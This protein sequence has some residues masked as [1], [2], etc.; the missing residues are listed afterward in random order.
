MMIN[1]HTSTKNGNMHP[2]RTIAGANTKMAAPPDVALDKSRNL[3][4]VAD[5]IDIP[6]FSSAATATGNIAP[7]RSLGLT[8]TVSAIFLDSTNDRLFA[9]NSAG[10]AI[11]VFD[12]ASTL[13]GPVTANRTI[14]GAATHLGAPAGIQI[15]G[16]GTLV[17]SNASSHNITIYNNA[18][19]ATG[20]LAPSAQIVCSNSGATVHEPSIVKTAGPGR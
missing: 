4:Y 18:A 15:D 2:E 10:N 6:V 11:A 1:D 20:N 3:L 13:N 19:V 5:D 9:A 12:N 7:A 14:V 8:F 16:A 17:G